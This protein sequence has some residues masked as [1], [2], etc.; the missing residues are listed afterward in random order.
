[1]PIKKPKTRKPEL[2]LSVR[3]HER[4]ACA[5][6]AELA[7]APDDEASV[8]FSSTVLGLGG[9]VACKVVDC[10]PGGLGLHT[11]VFLPRKCRVVLRL[12]GDHTFKAKVRVR[13]VVMADR[14]P[15]YYIGC[16]FEDRTEAFDRTVADLLVQARNSRV[17]E[18][19][20]DARV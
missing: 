20:P 6:D 3:Q 2:E 17:Q 9:G 11:P 10:S 4:F 13:R 16:S 8:R 15:T 14:Q 19:P 12:T 7:I 1:M 18:E 5:W